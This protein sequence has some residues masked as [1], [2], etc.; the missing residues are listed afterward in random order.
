MM[1][2]D[3]VIEELKTMSE[4]IEQMMGILLEIK[5]LIRKLEI[6][7]LMNEAES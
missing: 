6:P 2:L 4:E 7:E 3:E 1:R 5:L